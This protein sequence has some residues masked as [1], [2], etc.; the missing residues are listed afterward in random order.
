VK[1]LSQGIGLAVVVGGLAA[2][3]GFQTAASG[4]DTS[5]QH[6]S[7]SSLVSRMENSA[8]G[9][10]TVSRT[11]AT[12]RVAMIRRAGDGDLLPSLK[13]ASRS[14][15]VRKASVYLNSYAPAFGATAHQLVR[16]GTRA[17]RYGWTVSFTQQFHGIPVF[18]SML[19]AQVDRSGALT[20]VNGYAVPLRN[21][22]TKAQITRKGAARRAV[23]SVRQD[24]P[25]NEKGK[26][27]STRGLTASSVKKF[28][29]RIGTLKAERGPSVLVYRVEVTNR[30]NIRDMVFIDA[31]TGKLVNRY[32]LIDDDTNREFYEW[33]HV[34]PPNQG[35][36]LIWKEGDDPTVLSADQKSM[37][38]STGDAYWLFKDTFGRDSYD[39]AGAIMKVHNNDP[40]IACPNANWNGVTTNYCDG[41]SSDDVVSHEWGHAYTQYTSGLI[42]QWQA[43]ALNESYSDVWGETIDQ[44]NN[45]EDEGEDDSVRPTQSC[46]PT[47]PPKLVM[48]LTSPAAVAG[49]CT[50]VAA[51]FGPEFDTTGVT[52]TAIVATDPADANGPTTTDGCTAYTNAG[53][54]SGNWAYVDRGTC[55]FQVKADNAQAAGALGV[56]VGN[57]TPNFPTPMAGT[58]TIYG[59]MVTQ[60]DGTRIK[61]ANGPVGFTIQAEDT[62]TRTGD[63][64][65][66]IGEK[67]PAFGGAIRDMWNPT[68]YGNPG[69]VTDAEYTC[70]VNGDQNDDYGGVHGNSGVPNHT[71]A[72]AVDG[73]TYNGVTTTGL[74]IDK[75]ANI[76]FYNQTHFLTP[77]SGF[78]EMADGLEASCAALTGQPINKINVTPNAAPVAVSSITANDCTQLSGAIAA[79]QLRTNPTQCAFTPILKP[80]A[81]SPC[82]PGTKQVNV[83][84]D[85]FESGLGKWTANETV[86]YPGGNGYPWK[87]ST[88]APHHSGG[89][90]F[91]AD[92]NV[93]N[94]SGAAGDI[95]SSDSITSPVI[96]L[97]SSSASRL[98]FDHY[99]ASEGGYDGGNVKISVNGG[100]FTVVPTAAYVFNPYN[101]TLATS[102]TNTSPLAGQTAFTGTNRG[103]LTGSWGT[104]LI[105]L[106]A[107]G[108][109]AGDTVRIRFDM[110]RDGCGGNDGWYVDN[111]AVVT[112][113]AATAVTAVHL[114]EPSTYGS[115][116]Q[117]KVT[118]TRDGNEGE[119]PTGEVVVKDP[120][121][122]TVGQG[123]L[124]D[125]VALVDLPATLPVGANALT[126]RYVGS[127]NLAPATT[128]VTATVKQGST[129]PPTKTATTTHVAKPEPA[130]FKSDLPV[131]VSVKAADHSTVTGKVTITF[132]GKV[133]GKAKLVAGKVKI[134]ITK[135]L[136]VGKHKLVA[137][138][139]GSSTAKASSAK[140]TIKIVKH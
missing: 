6:A 97:P 66:L 20:A 94:C 114:P 18:G 12:G 59:V 22:S 118:V 134:T 136:K 132:H 2:L 60:A 107:A 14:D 83:F 128:P 137:H 84:S 30:R 96:A 19:K 21:L 9:H 67:S 91:A 108:A 17:D 15:A 38:D 27:G 57:N 117:V 72:Y 74:G 131:R 32:T 127:S 65:W 79:T 48:T 40:T 37:V 102:A 133:I 54:V 8:R 121:G 124:V 13:G 4:N 58:S 51:S 125:G 35:F 1:Y 140:F 70:G 111:V 73:G 64:R 75:A 103:S 25:T 42:Y 129:P 44:V 61:S 53:A 52:A 100:A 62:S 55:T 135:N 68:C 81:P 105:D 36:N 33:N 24:P 116:S 138:Y 50:S 120:T 109:R 86:V 26:P 49:P 82:G 119:T 115:A 85:D 110:G 139:L 45:R 28:V 78:P 89:V 92:P 77:T 90:A 23:G 101:G 41:V 123:T 3:P 99:V 56:I 93:G 122:A 63:D 98:V 106:S 69:K 104:S 10:V 46:D 88:S 71:Y 43:G 7:G 80:G 113:K 76:W 130:K 126:A 47:A 95:S 39:N 112:C 34:A 16:A 87:A 31:H 5:G 29:Y 11:H